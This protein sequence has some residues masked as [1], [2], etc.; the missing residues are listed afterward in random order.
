MSDEYDYGADIARL[1]ASAEK[2]GQDGVKDAGVLLAYIAHHLRERIE[3]PLVLAD[4]AVRCIDKIR[5]TLSGVEPIDDANKAF[6]LRPGS[7]TKTGSVVADYW[8]VAKF[9]RQELKSDTGGEDEFVSSA[10]RTAATEFH[11]GCKRIE[12]IYYYY[13][14]MLEAIEKLNEEDPT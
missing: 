4:Y 6:N 11:L 10:I 12:E 9:V 13:C 2:G 7:G 8:R 1:I 3:I 14:P 5:P